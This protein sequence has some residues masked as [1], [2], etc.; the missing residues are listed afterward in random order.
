MNTALDELQMGSGDHYR[1]IIDHFK[2]PEKLSV[3]EL[4][5]WYERY[6]RADGQSLDMDSTVIV[7]VQDDELNEASLEACIIKLAEEVEVTGR[8]CVECQALF[9]DY[10]D[11]GDPTI[12]CPS[13]GKNW[14]GSGMD[15]K[16]TVART[17]HT[18][19]V[20][21]ASR[22]GC[23]MCALLLQLMKDHDTLATFRRVEA[24]LAYLKSR[25]LAS[26]SVQNWGTNTS[27][28]LWVNF[29]GKIN[30]HCN[31]AVAQNM[32][33]ESAALDASGKISPTL[34]NPMSSN[35]QSRYP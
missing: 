8:F 10:P 15:W 12:D 33:F 3:Q 27:Q 5:S 19:V 23:K 29:P 34:Q 6:T 1:Q 30:D 18:F 7:D 16:H 22:R 21:A 13:T 11:L 2:K 35:V 31:S 32:K 20:E 14:P 17:C 28:L 25:E 9:D 26:L 24:R 4:E